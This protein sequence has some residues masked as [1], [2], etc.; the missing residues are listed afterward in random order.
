MSYALRVALPA[1]AA[2]GALAAAHVASAA[3]NTSEKPAPATAG[4]PDARK[5]RR[6][7]D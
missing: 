3:A 2:A 4:R 1:L 7:A 6:R 5:K